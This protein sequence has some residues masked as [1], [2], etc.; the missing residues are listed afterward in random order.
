MAQ[1]LKVVAIPPS[2]VRTAFVYC[3]ESPANHPP[4][5]QFYCQ[6]H[7]HIGEKFARF[8]FVS[9]RIPG[10]PKPGLTCVLFGCTVQGPRHAQQCRTASAAS[11]GIHVG[12]GGGRRGGTGANFKVASPSGIV[13]DS[14]SRERS[15]RSG[16]TGLQTRGTSTIVVQYKRV[17]FAGHDY[18]T[19]RERAKRVRIVLV[20]VIVHLNPCDWQSM[21]ATSSL[22]VHTYYEVTTWHRCSLN[23]SQRRSGTRAR[24]CFTWLASALTSFF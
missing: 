1:E 24:S 3:I 20:I 10:A 6:E 14:H 19:L 7:V 22:A 4:S 8:A 11:E 21:T 12:D 13:V 15:A 16:L 23:Q 2:E 9:T 17:K 5:R 18:A